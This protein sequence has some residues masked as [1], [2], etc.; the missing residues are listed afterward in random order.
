MSK[1]DL[2]V[3]FSLHN[4]AVVLE[5]EENLVKI[6]L[7]DIS[8]MELRKKLVKSVESFFASQGKKPESEI[9]CDFIPIDEGQLKH[10]I[11]LRYGESERE[12]E[13][14]NEASEATMLLDTLLDEACKKGA[15]DIHIEEK[16]VRFRIAGKLEDITELSAE[17]SRELVRRIKVLSNLNV[18]ES[19]RAQDGQFV[20]SGQN[21]VFVRVSCLPSFSEGGA[22]ESVV[23]RLLNVTRI[24]LSLEEL[25]FSVD[26]C[27]Q[28][29]KVLQKEQG[30]ILISGATGSGKST[31]AASLLTRLEKIYGR[32][33]K[34]ITIEDPPEYLLDGVTQ[35]HVDEET[36]MSFSDALRF[37]FRQDPDVIFVGEIRDSLTAKTVLQ[38]S[39]TGHLVFATVHTG[40]IRETSIRMRE[41]G[42]DFSEFSTVLLAVIFQKLISDEAGR[43][44]LEAQ[45]EIPM[46][47][48]VKEVF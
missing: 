47:E 31:T 8:N 21:Q 19:R 46:A 10:E 18:L 28:L 17:K 30:L 27:G 44:G 5:S 1:F 48:Q 25:G 16:C 7:T 14:L 6:G 11:S 33:K 13:R 37:I 4:G 29:E 41:L 35:I 26:Q 24:P 20:F 9:F 36:G 2:S 3:N 32:R 42:V 39:L 12:N 15:T 22:A 23:L 34:I 45:I 40:G 43:V 38:A